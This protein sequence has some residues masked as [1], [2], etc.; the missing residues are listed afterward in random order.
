MSTYSTPTLPNQGEARRL[1]DAAMIACTKAT[2]ATA[3]ALANSAM[4]F[5]WTGTIE[6]HRAYVF[7]KDTDGARIYLFGAVGA[8]HA[9]LPM[10]WLNPTP[11]FGDDPEALVA[12]A[13]A[14]RPDAREL[15]GAFG[16]ARRL[17]RSKPDG[18]FADA[19]IVRDPAGRWTACDF[20]YLLEQRIT[21]ERVAYTW[22]LGGMRP[23]YIAPNTA[24]PSI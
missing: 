20:G 9:Y 22:R 8:W 13:F 15:A 24:F 10:G 19:Y 17:S 5:E 23:G 7:D 14:G 21:A 18:T 4:A 2:A 12:A 16:E 1:I 6:G 3:T 11:M